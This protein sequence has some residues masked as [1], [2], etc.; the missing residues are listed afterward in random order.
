MSLSGHVPTGRTKVV[1]G[2]YEP[3]VWFWAVVHPTGEVETDDIVT[4][5]AEALAIGLA[6]LEHATVAGSRP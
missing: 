3:K 4:T 5:H 2:R 6:A 1:I